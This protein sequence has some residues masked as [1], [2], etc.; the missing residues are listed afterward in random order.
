[1]ALAVGEVGPSEPLGFI[2]KLNGEI[3]QN[4]TIVGR[5]SDFSEIIGYVSTLMPLAIGAG[6]VADLK[7]SRRVGSARWHEH[8]R[9]PDDKI[10]VIRLLPH[11][12]R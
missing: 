7:A 11:H 12:D 3:T 10:C 5:V 1:M 4:D 8:C 6:R 9:A 2:V